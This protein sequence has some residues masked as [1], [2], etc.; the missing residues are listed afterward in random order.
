MSVQLECLT[1]GAT[2]YYT[3]DGSTPTTASRKYTS[4]FVIYATT[5][6]KA[7]AFESGYNPSAVATAVFTQR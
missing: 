6:V 5:T 3:V 1:P 7:A 2:I 4:Y